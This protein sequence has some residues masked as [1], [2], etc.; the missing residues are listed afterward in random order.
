[1]AINKT[2]ETDFGIAATYHR[3][4]SYQVFVTNQVVNALVMSYQNQ[5]ARADGNSPLKMTERAM[6]LTDFTSD[7]RPTIYAELSAPSSRLV[8]VDGEEKFIINTSPFAGGTQ[9]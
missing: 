9:I 8:V 1:M 6:R 2:V 5:Q 3:I 4:E 7:P